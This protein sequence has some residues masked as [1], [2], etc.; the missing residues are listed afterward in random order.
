MSQHFLL[1][2]AARTLSLRTIYEEGEDAAYRRFCRL[3]WPETEGA[4]VCPLCGCLDIYDLGTRRR[5]K[6]AACHRQFSV[7]SGTVFASRKLAFVD[8]LG[9]ICLFVNA[10]KG[11]SAVQLSRDLDVQHKTAFVLMHKL[12]ETMTLETRETR[13]EG[14]VEVDGAVFGGHVRPANARDDRV[15]RRLLANRSGKRRVV[16]VLRQRGGRT[17]PRTFLREAQAV[18]FARERVA[19][20]SVISADEVAHWDA[21]D[22]DFEMKRV[23]HSEAYSREGTHTNLAESYFSRLRRM[24]GGQ[25]LRVEGHYL[26][27]YAAHA[28]WLEDHR[29]DSNGSLAD[30]LIDGALAAPVSRAWKGYW[31]RRA[32]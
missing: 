21:L 6:C 16:V 32:A 18:D 8:L 12:R 7:T 28:A 14:E 30:R 24:I 1:S 27:A 13:L 23:N 5:F 26:D 17:L 29:F 22:P 4:P 25:H 20:G 11:L 3:R 9:A 2:A 10:A 15:D 19:A 31:Q